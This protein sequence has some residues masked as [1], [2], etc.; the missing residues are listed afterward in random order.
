M[1]ATGELPAGRLTLPALLAGTEKLGLFPQVL[2]HPPKRVK[3]RIQ[4]Y[5]LLACVTS[6]KAIPMLGHAR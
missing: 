6:P 5:R 2:T 1:A 3:V 4:P